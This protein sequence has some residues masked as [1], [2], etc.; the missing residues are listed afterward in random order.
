MV[1]HPFDSECQPGL[2][3]GPSEAA[4]DVPGIRNAGRSDLLL[5]TL[6]YRQE[7]NKPTMDIGYII[8]SAKLCQEPEENEWNRVG[9]AAEIFVCRGVILAD[10]PFFARPF[11]N[12]TIKA[13][14]ARLPLKN[15]PTSWYNVRKR[16]LYQPI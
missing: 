11:F 3:H 10:S 13:Q 15:F 5:A 8:I 2:L 16:P 9:A 1:F 4:G 7:T 12:Y 6:F 14:N